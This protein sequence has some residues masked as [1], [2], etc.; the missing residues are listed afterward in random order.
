MATSINRTAP[1]ESFY[2]AA[3]ISQLDPCRIPRHIA[4]IPDGNRRW[5]K[6]HSVLTNVGHSRGGDT[7]LDVVKAAKELGVKVLTCFCFSTENWDR[8]FAEVQSFMWLFREFLLRKCEETLVNNIKVET[9]GEL[10]RLPRHLQKA[11]AHIKET[12]AHCDGFEI[13]LAVNYGSRDELCRA[14]RAIVTDCEQ[15]KIAKEDISELLV[16]RYLDT[17]RWG[18]PEL[19]IRTSGERRISNYLLWQISYAEV[20]FSDVLWP[21]FMPSH[22]LKALRDFQTRE[23]RLGKL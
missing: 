5:A 1:E 9:I 6:K 17:A 12:T 4:I 2:S 11:I 16:S 3:E 18:D 21:D 22:L 8:S 7:L 23:R 20:Y 14:M 19:I 10:G 15:G 13:V